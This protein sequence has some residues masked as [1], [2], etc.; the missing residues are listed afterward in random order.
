MKRP[1]RVRKMMSV[2][3]DKDQM[4]L[5]EKLSLFFSRETNRSFSKNR[6]VEEA[7]R[8]FVEDSASYI[9]AEYDLDIHGV[10]LT[11]MQ[12]YKQSSTV[13]IGVL[14]TVVLPVRDDEAAR[15]SVFSRCAWELSRLD[16]E[17]LGGMKYAAFYFC[18]PTCSITHYA[19]LRSFA[20]CGGDARRQTIRFGTPEELGHTLEWRQAGGRLRR[21][22]YT[23]FSLLLEAKSIEE[24]F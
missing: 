12:R 18:S 16:R 1:Q 19:P 10:T 11:E 2:S 9:A 6:V 7:V 5:I 17:K 8:A 14:D 22:R 15:E 23:A 20:P 3:L 24:L 13:D 21:P 4:E